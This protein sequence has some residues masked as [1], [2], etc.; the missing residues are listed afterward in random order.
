MSSLKSRSGVKEVYLC[1]L[2]GVVTPWAWRETTGPRS[3]SCPGRRQH[4]PGQPPSAPATM[5][6]C[7]RDINF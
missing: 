7:V 6:I 4:Q 2:S 1:Y 5:T 3:R